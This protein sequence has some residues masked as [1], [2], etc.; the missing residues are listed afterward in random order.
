[1]QDTAMTNGSPVLPAVAM[2]GQC[3]A[4]WAATAFTPERVRELVAGL[5]EPFDASEIKWRVT[6]TCKVGGPK[7]P[8]DRGQM[9]A[10][11][12]PRAY[13]D[14][15]NDL[16]APSGWTRDYTVQM[17]Q[18]F[19]RKERGATERTIT[20]KI[21]VTCKVTI[22]GLG[23][24]AGLGEEWADNDNAGT[25]AEAQAFKRAC[26]C[27]GLGRYLYD[28]EGQWVDLDD[29]KRPLETPKLP[30]WA[31][32]KRQESRGGSRAT[33]KHQANGQQPTGA[34]GVARHGRG[35]LFRDE[36]LGQVKALCGTVGFCLSKGVLQAVA[37]VEDPDKIRDMAKLTAAFDK[38]QDLARGVERLRAAVTKTGD[39]RYSALCRELNLASES[40]DD[41]P[42]RTVLRRLVETLEGEG[43][44]T[45]TPAG[46]GDGAAGEGKQSGAASLSELRGRLLHEANR[47]S[48]ATRRPLAEVI[49]QAAKGS[50]TFA[51]LKTLGEADIGKVVTALAEIQRM[52]TAA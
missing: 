50:F 38:L 10:Y 31:R 37:K 32:P 41:I 25:A 6:N 3:T 2:N 33:G 20:A 24:H 8:R 47:V 12:D 40:I 29:K 21:V 48:G 46:T 4:A 7:G 26:S 23:T 9:L 52:E 17:V 42:D 19:E 14:R 34:N 35:G 51:N 49:N 36:L 43:S 1:M 30:D 45:Q 22:Y 13:T 5:E 28:L 27:F 44:S 15:L 18:N 11:A 16:F 39:Q